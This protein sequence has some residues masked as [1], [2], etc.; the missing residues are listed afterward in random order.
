MNNTDYQIK[1]SA[2]DAFFTDV[3]GRVSEWSSQLE[4]IQKAING[5]VTMDSFSGTSADNVKNYLAEVHSILY[6]AL[7]QAAIEFQ[8]RLLLYKDGYYDIDPNIYSVLDYDAMKHYYKKTG[9]LKADI[10]DVSRTISGA[11]NSVCDIIYLPNPST[12]MLVANMDYI[13]TQINKLDQSILVHEY[14]HV[15]GGLKHLNEMIDNLNN[16]IVSYRNMNDHIRDYHAGDY[17]NHNAVRTLAGNI[18][19]SMDFVNENEQ[20]INAAYER[21]TVTYEQMQA[22]LA[23]EAAADARADAGTAEIIM[24]LGAIVL[25]GAAIL[26]TGGAATPVVVAAYVAGGSSIVYGISNVA[27]GSQEVYYGLNGDIESASVNPIRDTI[28]AGNQSAYDTWGKLSMSVAGICIPVGKTVTTMQAAGASGGTVAKNVLFTIG[29]ETITDGVTDWVVG[30]VSNY[31]VESF[32]LNQ[33]QSALMQIGLS[34]V[35]GIGTNKLD[36]MVSKPK[37]SVDKVNVDIN[38]SAIDDLKA[39]DVEAKVKVDGVADTAK[40]AEVGAGLVGKN[41]DDIKPSTYAELMSPDDAKRYTNFLEN[42]SDNGLRPVEFEALRKVDDQLTLNKVDYDEIQKIRVEDRVDD[43]E[44]GLDTITYRRVQG[45]SG[46]NASQVRIEINEDGTI[47]IPNKDANL[48]IS[49][50]DGEHAKY[51]LNKRGDDAYIMEIDVPKWF[52][53]FLQENAISQVNYKKNPLNQGGMAPKITDVT[54]PGN[55]FELPAPWVGWL[56]EYG[57]NARVV[58]P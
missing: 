50:D 51:F 37:I 14:N 58:S 18:Q 48:S 15:N 7:W 26:C 53:D 17:L 39:V 22:D 16:M 45:G 49:I 35:A 5:I 41:V 42:G 4:A 12:G 6:V 24:G 20:K 27:E 36:D 33:T 54:T 8:S 23:A 25:G 1:Y 43:I 3:S 19:A 47:S 32:G 28:F 55:C 9:E 38:T 30:G 21:L 57:R 11:L 46:N 34:T 52:D 40:N 13:L 2:N 44:G 29:K 56:E 10:E 31:A